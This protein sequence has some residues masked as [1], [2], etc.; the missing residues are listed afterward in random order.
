MYSEGKIVQ[1]KD[2]ELCRYILE[3]FKTSPKKEYCMGW[4]QSDSSTP[5]GK[6]HDDLYDVYALLQGWR[7][8]C[9]VPISGNTQKLFDLL[10]KERIEFMQVKGNQ[11]KSF[12]FLLY[13]RGVPLVMSH[14]KALQYVIETPN[15]FKSRKKRRL[16]LRCIVIGML[17]GYKEENIVGY[18]KRIIKLDSLDISES[19][20][21]DALVQSQKIIKFLFESIL[22]KMPIRI[23]KKGM[24]QIF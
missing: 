22:M 5:P 8:I 18:L 3:K 24:N 11:Q 12:S 4:I 14:V 10:A 1:E 23:K 19:M 13:C 7:S 2:T 16:P 17:L 20:I 9:W 21:Q 15:L 6:Q